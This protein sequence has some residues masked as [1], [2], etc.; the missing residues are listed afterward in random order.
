LGLKATSLACPAC[1]GSVSLRPVASS[2]TVSSPV[3]RAAAR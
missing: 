2:Q 3:S 1:P